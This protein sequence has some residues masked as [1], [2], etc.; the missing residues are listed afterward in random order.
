MCLKLERK[1]EDGEE[2]ASGDSFSSKEVGAGMR[3][4]RHEAQKSQQVAPMD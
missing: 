2:N 3:E 4:R 1:M